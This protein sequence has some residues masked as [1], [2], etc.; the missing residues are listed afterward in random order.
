[1]TVATLH[2]YLLPRGIEQAA[3]ARATGIPSRHISAII[4]GRYPITT[5]IALRLSA[6][7]GTPARYRM[8]LQWDYEQAVRTVV[9]TENAEPH[10]TVHVAPFWPDRP[11]DGVMLRRGLHHLDSASDLGCGSRH[12]TTR[13][14]T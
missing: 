10:H 14:A 9:T 7:L 13:K 1:M 5:D 6:R 8:D 11:L 2:A 4:Q 12:V 3:L